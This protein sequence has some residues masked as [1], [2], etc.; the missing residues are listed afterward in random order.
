[1][2]IGYLK[3]KQKINLPAT[4][5]LYKLHCVVMIANSALLMNGCGIK[6]NFLWYKHSRFVV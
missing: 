2:A 3:K 4:C 1:M 5:N 6:H